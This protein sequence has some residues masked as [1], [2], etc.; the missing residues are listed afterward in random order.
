MIKISTMKSYQ[1]FCFVL[2]TSMVTS[3]QAQ[4]YWTQKASFVSK[5]IGASGFSIGDKGYAGWGFEDNGT[6]HNDF[7]EYDPTTDVWTQKA[8]FEGGVRGY[9]TGFGLGNKGYYGTGIIASYNW[10]KDFWEYDPATNDWTRKADFGGGLRYTAVSFAIGSKGYMG[11]GVYRVSPWYLA[12]Y[13]QDFW[14]YDP[15]ADSW[16]RKADIPERGR[17]NATGLSIADKGYVGM[18]TYYYDTRKKDW[19][20]YTPST[21]E[22]ARKADFKGIERYGA[23]GFSIGHKGYVGA[24]YYYSAQPDLWEFDPQTND[25]TLRATLPGEGRYNPVMFSIGNRGYYGLGAHNTGLNDFYE[26][27]PYT[28]TL[29]CPESI[30]VS[31]DYGQCEALVFA[32]DPTVTSVPLAEG[33]TVQYQL[34]DN[35][36][37]FGTG[38]GSISGLSFPQGVTLVRYSIPQES[39]S[40]YF[41]IDV[42]DREYPVIEIEDHYTLCYEDDQTYAVPLAVLTDNCDIK[43]VI[44][45]ITGETLRTGE[46]ND[47]SGYFD[48][49]TSLIE[50]I[51]TDYS[52]NV[53]SYETT[54]EINPPLSVTIPDLY[55]VNPGGNINTLYVGYGPTSLTYE[56]LPIGGTPYTDGSYLYA[57]SNGSTTSHSLINP[58]LPDSY[59]YSVTVT[60]AH[61]CTATNVLTVNVIDVR[62]G[63]NLNKVELC[64]VPPGNPGNASIIC[65]SSED[66][67]NLLTNGGHLS[68]C[69]TPSS[70]EEEKQ[71]SVFPNPTNGMFTVKIPNPNLNDIQINVSDKYGRMIATRDLTGSA[72]LVETTFDLSS[73]SKGIFFVNV[74]LGSQHSVLKVFVR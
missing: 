14:E 62:C 13:Y 12:T 41:T 65:I 9:G 2:I 23:A 52:D 17:A 43:S 7:W 6:A 18:G 63:K 54:I 35:D 19:W 26:Y 55:A 1:V 22:W 24:G 74:A 71:V 8:D 44:Y 59:N 10:T 31:T 36:V 27:T 49:G 28:V 51:V 16:T 57:W 45:S 29:T 4:D 64:R 30:Q 32:A 50:W 15:V 33:L 11:T 61:Q 3:M 66:A 39:L 34:I 42:V 67:V 47:A 38:E 48:V 73:Y 70:V 40:C 69:L 21:N 56:A 20:E 37:V 46:G 25:W 60:D 72:P 5:R 58:A 68:A 53:T